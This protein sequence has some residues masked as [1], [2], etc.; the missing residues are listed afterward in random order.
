M[1]HRQANTLCKHSEF[2]ISANHSFFF[3]L[4]YTHL[5]KKNNKTSE[6]RNAENKYS[7]QRSNDSFEGLA[8]QARLITSAYVFIYARTYVCY[9]YCDI[10][11]PSH[12]SK[13][14]VWHCTNTQKYF[15]LLGVITNICTRSQNTHVHVP[16][17]A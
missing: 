7:T 9:V 2:F 15:T 10:F 12:Q 17:A 14:E 6:I 1:M 16:A 8:G 3:I 4:F 13:K 11:R 5:Q